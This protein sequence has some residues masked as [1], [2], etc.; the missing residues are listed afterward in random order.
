[1]QTVQVGFSLKFF[2]LAGKDFGSAFLKYYVKAG[3]EIEIPQ[4]F[5]H[6]SSLVEV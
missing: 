2:L 1:M 5:L 3:F 4:N 6:C